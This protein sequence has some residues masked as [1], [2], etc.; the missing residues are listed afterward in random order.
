MLRELPLHLF[1]Q[2]ASMPPE[3]F[4]DTIASSYARKQD[5]ML[6]EA[7]IR[8]IRDFQKQYRALV[9]QT[10]KAFKTTERKILLELGMR[11]SVINQYDRITGNSILEVTDKVLRE[12]KRLSFDEMQKVFHDFIQYQKMHPDPDTKNDMK[13]LNSVEQRRSQ[14]VMHKLMG[15]VREHRESL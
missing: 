12:R 14:Q 7:K 6:H 15:L 4:M 1:E 2:E 10:A 3:V 9:Q 11:S 13:N 5:R 8:K